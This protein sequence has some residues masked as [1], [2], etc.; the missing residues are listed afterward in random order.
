[1]EQLLWLLYDVVD[2]DWLL[3]TRNIVDATCSPP[4]VGQTSEHLRG[5]V[6]RDQQTDLPSD[7]IMISIGT[8]S[9]TNLILREERCVVEMQNIGGRHYTVLGGALWSVK[10]GLLMLSAHW[11]ES[12]PVVSVPEERLK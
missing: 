12:P 11:K 2:V 3:M 7:T 4:S 5:K 6:R 8:D 9:S 1:M 10:P